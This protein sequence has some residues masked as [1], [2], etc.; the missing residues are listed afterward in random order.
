MKRFITT[1]AILLVVMVAGM[2]ALVV[3]VN[4]NDFRAY[5]I[6]Q[7]EQRNGYQLAFNGDLRW[8]V[9]PQ[10]SIL[11]GPVTLTAPGAAQPVVSAQNMRL[12]VNLLPLLSHQLS[13]KQ[14]MLKGAVVRLTQDSESQRPAD[15]PIGPVEKGNT[16]A[17]SDVT[18]GWKFDISHLR[19][20]DSLLVWQQSNGE[21][22]NVRDFNL[23][24]DQTQPRRAHL[25]LSSRINR[26]QRELQVNI[27]SDLDIADYPRHIGAVINQFDYQ[28]KGADLPQEGV[29]GSARMKASWTSPTRQFSLQDI[30]LSANDSQ[31]SG[32][33]SGS[34]GTRPQV[35][36][37]LHAATLN[38]DALLGLNPVTAGDATGAEQRSGPA[39]VIAKLPEY[40]NANSPLNAMDGQLALVAD[41]LTWRGLQ[42]NNVQL[43]TAS[44]DGLLTV[45]TFS[46]KAADG[47]FSLPGTI[48]VRSAQTKVALQPD[49]KQFA[50]SPL[51]KG[52]ELPNNVVSGA[53]SLKGDFH[54]EG[55]TVEA[56]KRQWQG[57]ADLSI[58]N[59]QFAGLNFQQLIQRAVENN[60]TKVHGKNDDNQ[61]NLQQIQGH[62]A[63]NN[64]VFDFGRLDAQSD[65][66][67]YTGA[68][69]IDVVK[70][71]LDIRFGVTVTQGWSGDSTLVQRLQQTPV[72]LHIY[73]PWS[74]INYNLKV[75]QVLRDQLRDEARKR[76][77]QWIERN[78]DSN[79]KS[80]MNK[81]LKDL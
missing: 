41:K 66:L 4:P 39:P 43:D 26:D 71:T 33:V 59:A 14:V 29:K 76:L 30:S 8:H 34:L 25:T 16:S 1:L 23:A 27:D 55:L 70:R 61:P 13:V 9:W 36:A 12:D 17:V 72:P 38:L 32:T 62:V 18:H 48:D 73:G 19:I 20:A 46:G 77:K 11:S 67:N 2:T 58:Q 51:L 22:L 49:L 15:A 69:M 7:V 6:R 64:G 54:G 44:E 37:S 52:F 56:F 47:S 81:I 45:K 53:L 75:D 65:Q 68:G 78:P 42:M 63:L 24:L 35:V 60:S 3:L 80:D 31:L 74:A 57:S 79:N 50:L 5:M 21:Q 28:L 10:L 40:D